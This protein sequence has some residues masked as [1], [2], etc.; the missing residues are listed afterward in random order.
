MSSDNSILND[1]TE[2][3]SSSSYDDE[4]IDAS[5]AVIGEG[6]DLS[7]IAVKEFVSENHI[8]CCTYEWSKDGK[9]ELINT[10]SRIS[11]DIWERWVNGK[12][13][14]TSDRVSGNSS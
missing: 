14:S 5:L 2:K 11:D 9:R 7:Y 1:I 8:L 13:I 10:E 4:R 12:G 3:M 6:L